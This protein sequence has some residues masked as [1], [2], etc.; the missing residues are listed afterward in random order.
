[1]TPCVAFCDALTLH[2]PSLLRTPPYYSYNPLVSFLFW[3]VSGGRTGS[4]F[5][6]LTGL[7]FVIFLPQSP[8]GWD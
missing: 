6:A 2:P 7:E 3:G 5:V 4:C 1:M 8:G